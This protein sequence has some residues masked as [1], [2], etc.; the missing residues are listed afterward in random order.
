MI[1]PNEG[2]VSRQSRPMRVLHSDFPSLSPVK[3]RHLMITARLETEVSFV[4]SCWLVCC[5]F[6]PSNLGV[7]CAVRKNIWIRLGFCSRLWQSLVYIVR[8][9]QSRFPRL[10]FNLHKMVQRFNRPTTMSSR[11]KKTLTMTTLLLSLLIVK[12]GVK[13]QVWS[14]L[15]AGAVRRADIRWTSRTLAWKYL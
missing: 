4:L 6:S 13:V 2:K 7:W 1:S 9:S 15:E 10:G 3:I 14:E 5:F 12:E 8:Y 11:F